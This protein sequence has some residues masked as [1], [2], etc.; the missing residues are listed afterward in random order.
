MCDIHACIDKVCWYVCEGIWCV[1]MCV[2]EASGG[3]I[4]SS[5]PTLLTEAGG[6]LV[7]A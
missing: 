5:F 3:Q 4:F 1:Y 2:E 6:S 7:E